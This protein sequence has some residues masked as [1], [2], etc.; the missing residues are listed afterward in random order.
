MNIKSLKI[1]FIKISKRYN[2]QWIFKNYSNEINNSK[3]NYLIAE[4]GAGKSTLIKIILNLVDY[5]GEIK[6]TIKTKTY[7]PEKINLPYFIK[8]EDFFNLINLNNDRKKELIT[9]LLIE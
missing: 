2:K 8:V 3:I 4:N 5:K 9:K 1:E 6:T 7:V